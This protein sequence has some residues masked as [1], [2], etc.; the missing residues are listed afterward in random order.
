MLFW[1]VCFALAVHLQSKH[2]FRR[3]QGQANAPRLH[4]GARDYKVTTEQPALV[5]S[6][7]RLRLSVHEFHDN[8]A[9]LRDD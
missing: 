5:S 7:A 9:P 8:V 3:V 6:L 2:C 4:I 1:W